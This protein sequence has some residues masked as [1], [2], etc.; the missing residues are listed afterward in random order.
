M[1]ESTISIPDI[2][3]EAAA[4]FLGELETHSAYFEKSLVEIQDHNSLSAYA[5]NFAEKFHV[6]KGGAGF[7]KLD[8]LRN[9]AAHGET[10]LKSFSPESDTD[11]ALKQLK[12]LVQI[13]QE[14]ALSLKLELAAD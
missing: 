13:L 8:R 10:L 1:S 14:E 12:E 5:R 2:L 7:L 9:A 3:R 4:I 6:I 11:T